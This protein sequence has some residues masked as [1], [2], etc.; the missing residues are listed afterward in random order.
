MHGASVDDA[1]R[2]RT[3]QLGV[4]R[5]HGA[6]RGAT[7]PPPAPPLVLSAKSTVHTRYTPEH[8]DSYELADEKERGDTLAT[9]RT[10]SQ[11]QPPAPRTHTN[12]TQASTRTSTSTQVFHRPL[13]LDDERI[14]FTRRT[15]DED[16]LRSGNYRVRQRCR[17]ARR[18][19]GQLLAWAAAPQHHTASAP[20][21]PR[22]RARRARRG[23]HAR[24][25]W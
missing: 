10:L 22:P 11:R 8:A 17:V 18:G 6:P 14:L 20:H 21:R 7:P 5:P 13:S 24:V 16:H 1:R 15:I 12:Q 23:Q 2:P 25:R 9:K 3:P 4:R 19:G